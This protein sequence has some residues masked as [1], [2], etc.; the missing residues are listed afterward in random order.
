MVDR[1]NALH[2]GDAVLRT[3]D[4]GQEQGLPGNDEKVGGEGLTSHE[5]WPQKR[6]ALALACMSEHWP[7]K[8]GVHVLT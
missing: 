2:G 8:G 4:H 5:D 3:E 7:A 1:D 6:E